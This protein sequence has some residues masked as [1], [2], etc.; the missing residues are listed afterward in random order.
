MLLLPISS[1]LS[2]QVSSRER[3][4]ANYSL[5][6]AD[7]V[8]ERHSSSYEKVISVI[9]D[10][11]GCLGLVRTSPA[12]LLDFIEQLVTCH[13]PLATTLQI[14][15]KSVM[16]VIISWLGFWIDAHAAPARVTLAILMVFFV[17]ARWRV[18]KLGC[19]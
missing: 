18:L 4:G 15:A 16:F 14:I 5:L 2:A 10:V 12:S 3:A 13:R 6:K 11:F 7:F 1:F 17:C 9:S 19:A 8:L